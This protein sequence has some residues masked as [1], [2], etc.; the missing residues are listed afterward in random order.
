MF[1]LP[2]GTE[3]QRFQAGFGKEFEQPG[4]AQTDCVPG[5]TE[6][7][8]GLQLSGPDRKCFADQASSGTVPFP[9]GTAYVG[10]AAVH[11]AGC[12]RRRR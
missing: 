10:L 6:S 1:E 3:V 4:S 11:H 7:A 5:Q 8:A 2:V 12:R 9:A